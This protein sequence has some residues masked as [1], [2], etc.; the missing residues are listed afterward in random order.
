VLFVEARLR[1][2][3]A[4]TSVIG[5]PRRLGKSPASWLNAMELH[6]TPLK[7]FAIVGTETLHASSAAGESPA[8]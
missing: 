2:A 4:R 3:I 7:K 8:T 1:K 5:S 6:F